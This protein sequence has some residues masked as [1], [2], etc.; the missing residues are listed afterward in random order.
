MQQ[1]LIF[2]GLTST[3]KYNVW[4]TKLSE[5]IN[6]NYLTIDQLDF[7]T[8]LRSFL[9]IELFEIGDENIEL[10]DNFIDSL[11]DIGSSH[12]EDF[13]LYYIFME[14]DN[15]ML[16]GLW[17]DYDNTIQALAG[18][19]PYAS[20]DRCGCRTNSSWTCGRIKRIDGSRT[21]GGIE[22]DWGDCMDIICVGTAWGCG[23]FWAYRCDGLCSH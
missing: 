11:W 18:P 9:T 14:L 7:V 4:F 1:R 10:L 5:L 20:S 19:G 16:F 21:S 13:E 22:L 15:S 3:D 6:S 2:S 23:G 8:N 17:D 12:F